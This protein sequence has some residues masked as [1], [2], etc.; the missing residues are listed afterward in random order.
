MA[1]P[2]DHL[3]LLGRDELP[4]TLLEYVS[5][6]D[7]EPY[8]ASS[9]GGCGLWLVAR[10]AYGIVDE[11]DTA[12]DV[13]HCSP[14]AYVPVEYVGL[15]YLEVVEDTDDYTE[16]VVSI[17]PPIEKV[18]VFMV[19]ED[20]MNEAEWLQRSVDGVSDYAEV[21][22][23]LDAPLTLLD[24]EAYDDQQVIPLHRVPHLSVVE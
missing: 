4:R 10:D 5:Y 19:R 9:L 14:G 2:S 20:S 24:Q 7:I 23:A 13:V 6:R 17:T 1:N 11:G 16:R 22:V 3:R 8:L 15:R 12:A 21:A 18:A